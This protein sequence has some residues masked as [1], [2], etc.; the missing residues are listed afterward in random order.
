MASGLQIVTKALQKNGVLTASEAPD[1]DMAADGISA[2]NAM[3]SSW[4]NDS[5]TI[6]ARVWESFT[7]TAGTSLYTI[8]GGETFNTP[9]PIAILEGCYTRLAPSYDEPISVTTDELYNNIVDKT[10]S[11]RP[12]VLSYDNGFPQGKIRLWPVPDQSYTLF[13]LSEKSLSSVTLA[14][15]IQFPP[16]WERALVFNLAIELCADYSQPI[17]PSLQEVASKS[18]G[19][20]ARAVL[21]NRSLQSYPSVSGNNNIYTGWY[22]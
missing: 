20:I 8:G 6:Y 17:T 12:R 9:H 5:L 3:L 2:L 19:S 13:L 15:D 11:G 4:S 16:G 18:K 22:G 14:G 21:K 7:L 10:T 1:A